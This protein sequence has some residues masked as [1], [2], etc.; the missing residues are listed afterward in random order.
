MLLIQ[1]SGPVGFPAVCFHA[2][3]LG[4]HS[5]QLSG[6]SRSS[7]A[8]LLSACLPRDSAGVTW[9]GSYSCSL[10]YLQS[11][12][13]LDPLEALKYMLQDGFTVV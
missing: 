3:E 13:D 5:T 12:A 2:H 6:D 1:W 11:L 9:P 10:L 7:S 4:P 8:F